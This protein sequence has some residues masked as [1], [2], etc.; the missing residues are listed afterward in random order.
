MRR[1]RYDE[2]YGYGHRG[3]K[4]GPGWEWDE[5]SSDPNWRGGGYHGMRMSGDPYHAAYGFYRESH[6]G[7]LGGH[8]GFDGRYDLADGR[9]DREGIYHEADQRRRHAAPRYAR[10]F[11]PRW[12]ES[13]G[14]TADARYLRQYNSQSPTL[15]DPNARG[16]G[17]APGP[18]E[19]R[20]MG[21]DGRDRPTDERG[22]PG[23]NRG[24]FSEGKFPGPGTRQSNPQR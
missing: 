21:R 20:M 4:M 7:D 22:Y 3:Y 13:G 6:E 19:P 15:R 12:E 9:F 17:Y 2:E 18:D 16:W 8:G 11:D 14:V 23:Y 1:Y 24:G 5:Q 10:D